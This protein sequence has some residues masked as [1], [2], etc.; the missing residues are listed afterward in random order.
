[1]SLDLLI[2]YSSIDYAFYKIKYKGE[3]IIAVFDG[4]KQ[5]GESSSCIMRS[6]GV[7]NGGFKSSFNHQIPY[8]CK[9]INHGISQRF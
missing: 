6:L 4:K 2:A 3:D 1:M 9:A 8:H 7:L 5:S